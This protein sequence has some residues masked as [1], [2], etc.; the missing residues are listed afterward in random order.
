MSTP[1]PG[2]SRPR[3]RRSTI[4]ARADVTAAGADALAVLAFVLVG[5][6]SHEEGSVVLGTLTT[7]WPF[8]AGADLGWLA[9][10]GVRSSGRDW[11]A[12]SLPA[13]ATVLGGT[14]VGGML[15]RRLSG[16]GGTPVS[17]VVV[18]TSFL[19]LT[20]LGWRVVARLRGRRG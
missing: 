17:F 3:T 10:L 15:L 19:S 9:L 5:R 8:L 2:P 12:I 16:T 14:V 13:G 11:S 1:N 6:R 20:L 7:A 18:A 4:A